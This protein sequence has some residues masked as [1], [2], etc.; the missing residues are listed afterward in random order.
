[1]TADGPRTLPWGWYLSKEEIG[2]RRLWALAMRRVFRGAK[3]KGDKRLMFFAAMLHYAQ[4]LV[5]IT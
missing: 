1:M 2:E 3:R 4:S 5:K